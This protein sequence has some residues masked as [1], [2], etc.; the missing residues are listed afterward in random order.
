[1]AARN[2]RFG[3]PATKK[4]RAR[5]RPKNPKVLQATRDVKRPRL[6]DFLQTFFESR[7]VADVEFRGNSHRRDLRRLEGADYP[8]RCA[9]DQGML[10]KLFSFGDDRAR[11]D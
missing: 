2:I 3:P 7:S 6:A 10:G 4:P 5:R 1:M 11:A 8:R 9:D